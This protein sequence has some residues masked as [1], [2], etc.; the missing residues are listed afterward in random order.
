MRLFA[1][2]L[3]LLLITSVASAELLTIANPIG[4]GK[5]GVLGAVAQDQDFLQSSGFSGASLL[6]IGGYVGYGLTNQLDLLI[7]LGSANASGLLPGASIT[8]TSYGA[9]LKYAVLEESDAMPVSVAVAG[10]YKTI[11][12]KMSSPLGS[13]DQNGAQIAATVGVSKIIAPFAPYGAVAYK[14]NSQDGTDTGSQVDA[15]IGGAV[16]WSEQGAIY[17][18]Y[19]VQ[20]LSPKT[21]SSY[22]VNQIALGAGYR[23]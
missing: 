10:G 15:T 13:T 6:V 9:T 17:L 20:S 22:S 5:W 3:S 1:L 11:T 21:G 23:I 7:Q 12:M 8:G 2:L 14:M 18:E 4:Q 19:T 16:A